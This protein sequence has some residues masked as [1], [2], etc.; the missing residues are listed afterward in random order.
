[1]VLK[2]TIFKAGLQIADLDRDGMLDLAVADQGGGSV[3]VIIEGES[4]T[5]NTTAGQTAAQVA[6]DLAAAINAN[7]N[8]QAL[9]ITQARAVRIRDTGCVFASCDRPAPWCDIHHVNEWTRHNGPTNVANL[10]C[11]CTRHHTLVHNTQWVTGHFHLI[12]GCTTVIMYL[13]TAY[14]LWP[15]LTGRQLASRG[16]AVMQ[17]WLW[18]IG[19]LVLTLPWHALG[20]LGQPRRISSTPYD[21]PLVAQWDPHELAMIVGGAILLFSAVVLF[22]IVNLPVEFNA[23]SRAHSGSRRR[24]HRPRRARRGEV[25]R[26]RRGGVPVGAGRPGDRRRQWQ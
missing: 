3:S 10:V 13:A 7:A 17:L 21:S 9:G 6:Q 14:F 24:D 5:I 20:M 19:M 4:I 15:K 8:L 26:P 11:L 23:S 12:F 22:Q 25:P 1:M 18:T 16:M 2:A